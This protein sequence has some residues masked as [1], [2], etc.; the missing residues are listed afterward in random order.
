LEFLSCW[1]SVIVNGC[2]IDLE[3]KNGSGLG[4]WQPMRRYA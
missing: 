4:L 3:R 1:H 2:Y